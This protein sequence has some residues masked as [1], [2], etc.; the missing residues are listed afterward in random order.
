MTERGQHEFDADEY[1]PAAE[2][3]DVPADVPEADAL[4]QHQSVDEGGPEPNAIP[5][6]AP[7]ADVLEQRQDAG[8]EDDDPY[9]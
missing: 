8:P 9:D 4:E 2:L 7:E 6:D 5:P 1:E 3:D